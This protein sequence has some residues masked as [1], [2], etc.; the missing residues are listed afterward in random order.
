M[1]T[2]LISQNLLNRLRLKGQPI[3]KP[4]MMKKIEEV[5]LNSKK[6]VDGM[7]YIS[8]QI[9]EISEHLKKCFTLSKE[10]QLTFLIVTSSLESSFSAADYTNQNIE[11]NYGI[12]LYMSAAGQVRQ[13][14]KANTY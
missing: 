9:W 13:W 14:T 5:Q 2:Y 11:H 7:N 10:T 4:R 8:T 1:P 12:W 3:Q 6:H